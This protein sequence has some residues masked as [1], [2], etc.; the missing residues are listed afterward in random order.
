MKITR[1]NVETTGKLIL[2]IGQD[3]CL[4]VFW[5]KVKRDDEEEN[6]GSAMQLH[7]GQGICK[8]EV[9]LQHFIKKWMNVESKSPYLPT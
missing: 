9:A 8:S 7:T 6:L 2:K 1:T 5:L 4:P 3:C